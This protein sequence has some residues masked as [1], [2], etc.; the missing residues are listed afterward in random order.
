MT[1][2]FLLFVVVVVFLFASTF[3]AN[4]TINNS[5]IYLIV[6]IIN[7]DFIMLLN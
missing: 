1:R 5:I 2:C 3:P 6:I 7:D 4:P